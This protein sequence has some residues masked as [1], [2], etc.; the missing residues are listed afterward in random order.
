M[1][2]GHIGYVSSLSIDQ[3]KDFLAKLAP[4]QLITDVTEADKSHTV[5]FKDWPKSSK[6]TISMPKK[7][8][9]SMNMVPK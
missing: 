2:T 7:H 4:S 5:Y 1:A 3:D 8:T 6:S 9:I